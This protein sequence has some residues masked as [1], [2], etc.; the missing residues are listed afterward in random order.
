M[1]FFCKNKQLVSY[2]QVSKCFCFDF[3]PPDFSSAFGPSI[4][5]VVIDA[6]E[7]PDVGDGS[8]GGGGGGG[9]GGGHLSMG[10]GSAGGGGELLG[11][12]GNVHTDLL[13][14][15]DVVAKLARYDLLI[16]VVKA[17]AYFAFTG[18]CVA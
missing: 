18:E 1:F 9:P 8:S 12:Q 5:G 7:P 6:G 13:L 11:G 16:G 3:Q 17:E 15:K 4:D 2:G 10:G 14:R